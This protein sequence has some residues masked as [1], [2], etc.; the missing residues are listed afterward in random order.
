[1]GAAMRS[2]VRSRC[3]GWF[4][5]L[6]C[7]LP[8]AA[9]AQRPPGQSHF[10][11]VHPA[12]LLDHAVVNGETVQLS[13]L[14]SS[15]AGPASR[16][17]AEGIVLGRAPQPGSLRI[18][19]VDELR[20]AIAGKISIDVPAQVIVQRAGWELK[21]ETIRDAFESSQVLTGV[22]WSRAEI[23]FPQEFV[24]RSEGPPIEIVEV[25]RGRNSRTLT[26]RIRCRHR[27]D[28]GSFLAEILFEHPVQ[29]W[30][31]HISRP[32]RSKAKIARSSNASPVLVQ[33]GRR[34]VLVIEEDGLRIT[35]RVLPLKR[36]GWGEIVRAYDPA[37]RRVF[38]GQVRGEN[39]LQ[40]RTLQAKTW[41]AK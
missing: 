40:A 7:I 30:P 22:D 37:A 18:F 24:T 1:M 13:D 23:A 9:Q 35:T 39:L 4:L 34:A 20:N 26:A 6:A 36:A 5:S 15:A 29:G 14:M 31:L 25:E 8:G 41:E 27:A 32:D 10:G 17:L 12:S 28:C 19:R 21:A 11:S 16:L 3:W 38:L 2:A 33:P